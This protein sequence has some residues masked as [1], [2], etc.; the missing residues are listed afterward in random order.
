MGAGGEHVVLPKEGTQEELRRHLVT[1]IADA[2]YVDGRIGKDE[3]EALDPELDRLIVPAMIV[4]LPAGL[5]KRLLRGSRWPG[6]R[7]LG[8]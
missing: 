3:R 5:G 1:A 2:A 4:A 8:I 6:V 7:D